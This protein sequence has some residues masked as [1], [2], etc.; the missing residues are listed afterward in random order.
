MK[1]KEQLR[2][3]LP[4]YDSM[5]EALEKKIDSEEM[6]STLT[7]LK[8]IQFVLDLAAHFAADGE[9]ENEVIASSIYEILS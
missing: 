3:M 9:A 1:T 4:H 5:C 6:F 8:D 7:L 2:K